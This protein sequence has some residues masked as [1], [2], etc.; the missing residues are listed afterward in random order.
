MGYALNEI[1]SAYQGLYGNFDVP[2][3]GPIFRGPMR[4]LAAF[5]PIGVQAR[6]RVDIKVSDSMM[7]DG[8]HRER[9]LAGMYV[10]RDPKEP[11]FQLE[12]AFKSVNQ[13]DATIRKVQHAVRQKVLV[14]QPMAALITQAVEKQV[15]TQD[16]AAAIRETENL[17][18]EAIQ[19]DDFPLS[20]FPYK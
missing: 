18:R 12:R 16:Q 10:P 15:I 9:L 3:A 19:V 5:N 14:K 17:R 4:K 20:P 11:L 7:T 13:S 8:A 1:Q 2:I 6:D